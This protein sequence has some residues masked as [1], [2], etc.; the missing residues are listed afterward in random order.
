MGKIAWVETIA[1][2]KTRAVDDGQLLLTYLFAP[3]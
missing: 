2:A 3:G 1:G